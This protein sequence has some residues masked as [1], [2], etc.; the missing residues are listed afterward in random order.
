MIDYPDKET[1]EAEEIDIK[2]TLAQAMATAKNRGKMPGKL[3]ELIRGILDPKVSWQ[4]QLR[5]FFDLTCKSN[6]DWNRPNRRFIA[7]NLY[8]PSQHDKQIEKLIVSWDTSGSVTNAMI[9][10]FNAELMEILSCVDIQEI[11]LIQCDKEVNREEI[12]RFYNN[13]LPT[14][15]KIQGRGGTD[16]QPVFDYIEEARENPTALIYFT[17][18]MCT[19][20]KLEPGYPVL[21]VN[22]KN[23]WYEKPHFG[24]MIVLE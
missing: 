2:N 4:E 20:P 16:Y 7:E 19:F 9:Q 22:P 3:E 5:Q 17:D 8:L 12:K 23:K 1:T 15:I 14:E 24:E 6:Y 18:G 21:W 13:D 11:V 10:E